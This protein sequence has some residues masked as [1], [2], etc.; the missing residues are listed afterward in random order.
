MNTKLASFFQPDDDG[1]I[2][3]RLKFNPDGMN[4]SL[5]QFSHPA[6]PG[7]SVLRQPIPRLWFCELK[8]ILVVHGR[9]TQLRHTM[10]EVPMRRRWN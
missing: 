6:Q 5:F 2:S 10:H 8:W 7:A 4:R 1:P 9:F 3:H